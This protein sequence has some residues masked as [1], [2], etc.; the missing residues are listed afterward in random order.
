MLAFGYLPHLLL[1]VLAYREYR[2]AQLPV[3]YLRQEV[4]LVFHR[5]RT[6]HEPFP[7]V[8]H[9]CLRVVACRDEVVVVPHLLV[10]R[11]ELYHPVAHH[12][13]VGRIACAHLV[14]GV[15]C[16]AVPIFPVA[17]HHL[18]PAAVARGYGSSHLEVFLARAVPFLLFLRSY[19]D[20]ETVGMQTLARQFVQ[21]HRTVH[22]AREQHGD[23]LVEYI[24]V[25]NIVHDYYPYANLLI[26]FHI[27]TPDGIKSSAR[28]VTHAGICGE[29]PPMIDFIFTTALS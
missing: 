14:H 20:V 22:A 18:Q 9:L 8:Y 16:H 27:P 21:H 17:V 26:I 1:H 12:V 25:H 29:P 28:H 11:T 24:L 23:A 6:R 2:L 19:L 4:G 13:G 7:A 10:E 15:A 3:V 5:V